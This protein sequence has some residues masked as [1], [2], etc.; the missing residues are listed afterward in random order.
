MN[1][2]ELAD[3]IDEVYV[4]AYG[5]RQR[6]HLLGSY[7]EMDLADWIYGMGKRLGAVQD[8]LQALL[9]GEDPRGWMMED[10]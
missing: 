7:G 3:I 8:R 4:I 5:L 10:D 6:A 1:N 2:S 9:G